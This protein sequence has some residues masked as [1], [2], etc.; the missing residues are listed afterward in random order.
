MT[1]APATITTM[2]R[3]DSDSDVV[4][5]PAVRL[6]DVY[7]QAWA[8][9]ACDS[10]PAAVLASLPADERALIAAAV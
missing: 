8:V 2:T 9:Y 6:W 4:T 5:V 3:L 1:T 10:V 7:Q